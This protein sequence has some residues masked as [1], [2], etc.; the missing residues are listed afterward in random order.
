MSIP[1]SF[2]LV[3]FIKNEEAQLFPTLILNQHINNKSEWYLKDHVT[4][5]TGV[6]AD[7]N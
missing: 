5:K 7:E 1:F 3:N 2:F 6:M 4:L